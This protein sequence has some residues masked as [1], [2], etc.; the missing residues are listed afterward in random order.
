MSKS[1]KNPIYSVFEQ[2]GQKQQNNQKKEN[3]NFGTCNFNLSCKRYPEVL[4]LFGGCFFFKF[5]VLVGYA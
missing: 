4:P 2:Q 3:N 1:S 5:L